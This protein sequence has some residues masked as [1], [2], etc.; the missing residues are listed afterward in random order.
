LKLLK[1][2]VTTGKEVDAKLINA[3]GPDVVIVATGSDFSSPPITGI[4]KTVTATDVFLGNVRAGDR[5]IIA[6]GGATECEVA[7]FLSKQGKE[8]VIVE[9]LSRLAGDI[10]LINRGDLITELMNAD[11]QT[12][13]NS[14]I[15]E[16]TDKDVVIVDNSQNIKRIEADMV[17]LALGLS[18]QR[19]LAKEL[20]SITEVYV[21]G[22]CAEPRR[23][24]EAIKEGYRVGSTI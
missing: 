8:A 5:N 11:I 7:L 18:C 17:I 10:P 23:V 9:M 20:S 14:K 3:I 12:F 19:K 15:V 13:T 6:G 16:V 4:E 22:D 21:I 1:V 24:G 2:K